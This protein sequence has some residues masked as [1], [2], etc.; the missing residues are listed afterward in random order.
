MKI[1][2]TYDLRSAYLAMGY[3]EEETAEFDRESTIEAIESTLQQLGYETDRIGHIK[4]LVER[5]QNGDRW[6]LVFNICEGM[7][8][9]AREAQVPALLEAY[10]IP[11]VFS[12]PL[13]MALTLDKGMTKRVIRDAGIA[14]PDFFVITKEDDVSKVDLPFP[15]FVKPLAEGTGKGISEKSIVSDKMDLASVCHNLLKTYKQPVLVETFLS[16][17]EFTVGIVG[18]GENAKAVG[19]MEIVLKEHAEKGVYSYVNKEECE[20]L[21]DYVIT[22]GQDKEKCEK[23]ALE[24]YHVLNC[25][26]GGRV[27]IRYD[28][29]G[30]PSFL[31]VNPLPGM[32][33][34][35]SD[36]P[37]LCTL[38]GIAY[39]E[40]M[41]MIMDSAIQKVHQKK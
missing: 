5:L 17:R 6:D 10:N 23:L 12:S 22:T 8:G 11:C 16:G 26:D 20:E 31:E 37:I 24:A 34:E 3:S 27:D 9:I 38:N 41:K 15:L 1:G 32:H 25:E 21:I 30:N 40:L 33:P 13:V 36:L 4:Q 39:P 18:T 7:Y 14:T 2:F 19:C 35:H 28:H 29:E